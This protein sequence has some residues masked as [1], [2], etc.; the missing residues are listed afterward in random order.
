MLPMNDNAAVQRALL[1]YLDA[2]EMA[3][4]GGGFM[5]CSEMLSSIP[6]ARE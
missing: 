1:H 4:R 6:G 3:A 5:Q 2:H